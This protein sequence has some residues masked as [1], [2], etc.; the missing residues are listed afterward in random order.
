MTDFEGVPLPLRTSLNKRGYTELTQVQR[1]IANLEHSNPDILVSAPTGSGKTIAFGIALAN[2]LLD[3]KDSFQS[4]HLPLGLIITPTRELAAQVK[5]ELDWLYAP[6]KALI[7]SCVGGMDYRKEKCKLEHGVHFVV[8]TPGRL[9]DHIQRKSLNLLGIKAIV[10]DEADEMLDLGFKDDLEFILISASNKHRTLLFS[11]TLPSMIEKMACR[12][13]DHA[14]RIKTIDSNKQHIDI[15]YQVIPVHKKDHEKA[16][17]NILRF[18][19]AQNVL[20]FCNTR[21]AVNHIA[22][23]LNDQGFSVVALSGEFTQNERI[24]ALQTMRDGKARICVATDVAARGIDLP[25]LELVIHADLPQNPEILLH[26]S[27]RTGRAG[28]KGISVLIVDAQSNYN[29]KCLLKKGKITANWVKAPTASDIIRHDQERILANSYLTDPIQ[30]SEQRFILDLM[31]IHNP[32]QIAAA[33]LRLSQS[34][35]LAPEELLE[36]SVENTD[37]TKFHQSSSFSHKR[38]KVDNKRK[39]RTFFPKSQSKKKSIDKKRKATL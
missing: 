32:E 13:Q 3:K 6:T 22:S 7:A 34:K 12:Y 18:Y 17:I 23:R 1:A 8:G 11:A 29:A 16:I 35:L 38:K 21:V 9:R 25:N 19:D 14:V 20:V 37:N 5:R 30:I 15:Q 26:R 36:V 27:G 4:S 28:R 2:S 33:F 31:A 24:R 10:L 39:R